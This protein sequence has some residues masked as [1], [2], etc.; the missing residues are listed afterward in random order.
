MYKEKVAQLEAV[1]GGTRILHPAEFL[2]QLDSL[3]A[4]PGEVS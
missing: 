1:L 4:P 3:G 2:A